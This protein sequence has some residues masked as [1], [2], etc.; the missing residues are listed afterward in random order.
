MRQWK[1][2][3]PGIE[4]IDARAIDAIR[5]QRN[6]NRKHNP[7]QIVLPVSAPACHHN[8]FECWQTPPKA[9]LRALSVPLSLFSACLPHEPRRSR[10]KT[11][12]S[13]STFERPRYT[14]LVTP[15]VIT[16][17]TSTPRLATLTP[18]AARMERISTSGK[19]SCQQCGVRE[20]QKLT[21]GLGESR[22]ASVRFVPCSIM[23]CS[24]SRP[25]GLPACRNSRKGRSLR[26]SMRACA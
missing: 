14:L 3:H 7:N 23:L 1:R 20:S 22:D 15:T 5:H 24:A 6:P 12:S 25:A 26:A 21:I 16:L 10:W 9:A 11:S 13:R 18:A 19:R 2:R 17:S 4:I 8:G